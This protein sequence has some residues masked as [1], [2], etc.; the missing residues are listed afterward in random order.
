M[1]I[2][3]TCE[4]V[5]ATESKAHAVES[6]PLQNLYSETNTTFMRWR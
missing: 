4:C 2:E 6:Y 3:M 1:Y 5:L